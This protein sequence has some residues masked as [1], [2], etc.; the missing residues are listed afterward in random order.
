MIGFR[1][2]ESLASKEEVEVIEIVEED[3][4]LEVEKP[5]VKPEIKEP[6]H[7]EV[8]NTD[9]DVMSKPTQKL[10]HKGYPLDSIVQDYVN[11]AYQLWWLEFVALN[12]CENGWR[13]PHRTWDWG[14]SVGFCQIHWQWHKEIYDPDF[15][16]DWQKQLNICHQKW[17]N[18]TRFYW[19]DR[20]I[21]GQKCSSYV[22][23]RFYLE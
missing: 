23:D 18:G 13:D 2:G 12:E 11:Y 16:S 22:Q 17:S 14:W 21:K 10:I 7:A 8:D 5:E 4:K 15:K 20:L 1:F 19:P 3:N 9:T 6:T